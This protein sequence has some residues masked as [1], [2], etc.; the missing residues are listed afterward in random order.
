MS[1]AVVTE[2]QAEASQ[3][4][5]QHRGVDGEARLGQRPADAVL[6]LG[7]GPLELAT[8]ITGPRNLPCSTSAER[9]KSFL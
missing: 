4:I 8:P 1:G 7:Q 9:R 6:E 5:R 2:M 3:Q